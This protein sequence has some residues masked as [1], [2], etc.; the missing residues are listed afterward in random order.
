MTTFFY[1]SIFCLCFFYC[2]QQQE[3]LVHK[4]KEFCCHCLLFKNVIIKLFSCTN[5][6]RRNKRPHICM[7][8]VVYQN[9]PLFKFYIALNPSYFQVCISGI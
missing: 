5:C 7:A 6:K 2:Y 3:Y 9:E 8:C 4:L 1:G